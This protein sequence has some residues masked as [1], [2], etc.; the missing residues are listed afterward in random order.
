LI[1]IILYE[2]TNWLQAKHGKQSKHTSQADS[3]RDLMQVRR[4]CHNRLA[5]NMTH[6]ALKQ[7]LPALLISFSYNLHH[8]GHGMIRAREKWD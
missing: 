5:S 8:S 6:V 1:E 3:K 4:S 2:Y 7:T